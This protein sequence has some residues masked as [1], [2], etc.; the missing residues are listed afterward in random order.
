[1]HLIVCVC[2][3]CNQP[4][5]CGGPK[6]FWCGKPTHPERIQLQFAQSLFHSAMFHCFCLRCSAKLSRCGGKKSFRSGTNA[7]G[8]DQ[9]ATC[10]ISVS[11]CKCCILATKLSI[12]VAQK[13]SGP[14]CQGIR[15]GSNCNL[16]NL[17]FT[18]QCCIGAC[19]VQPNLPLWW[20][21]IFPVRKANASGTDQIATC[22]MSVSYCN[23]AL[24]LILCN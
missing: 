19:V 8:T 13:L 5:H 24:G 23:V 20:S 18:L 16:P 2:V 21:K 22:L 7:S 4:F 1:M 15:N 14:E 11:H 6:S 9:I 3:L 10:P 17:G 12:V